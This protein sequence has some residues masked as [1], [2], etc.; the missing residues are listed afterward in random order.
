MRKTVNQ[1]VFERNVRRLTPDQQSRLLATA[2]AMLAIRNQRQASRIETDEAGRRW[3]IWDP[4]HPL[5]DA[6]E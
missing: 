4:T 2:L 5:L 6:A 3:E 1:F